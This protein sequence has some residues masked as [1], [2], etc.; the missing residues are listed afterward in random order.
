MELPLSK[1]LVVS[2]IAGSIVSLLYLVRKNS[3]HMVICSCQGFTGIG[4]FA[5]GPINRQQEIIA[6]TLLG[7]SVI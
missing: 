6:G 3:L 1:T 7:M 4:E 5:L 2:M